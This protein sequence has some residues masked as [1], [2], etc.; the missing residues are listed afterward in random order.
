MRFYNQTQLACVYIKK[1]KTLDLMFFLVLRFDRST[2]KLSYL[3]NYEI[4]NA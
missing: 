3:S 2:N 1:G 4:N